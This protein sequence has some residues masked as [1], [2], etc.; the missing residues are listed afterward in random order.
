MIRVSV[1]AIVILSIAAALLSACSG[2]GAS[3]PMG[4][5][6]VPPGE[7]TSVQVRH[8]FSQMRAVDAATLYDFAGLDENEVQVYGTVTHAAAAS[9]LLVNVPVSVKQLRISYRDSQGNLHARAKVPVSLVAGQTLEVTALAGNPTLEVRLVNDSDIPDTEVYVI[10]TG[11]QVVLSGNSGMATRQIGSGQTVPAVNLKTVDP[12]PSMTWH[13]PYKNRDLPVYTFEVAH[14][15]GGRLWVS[16]GTPIVYTSDADPTAEVP[17]RLDKMEFAYRPGSGTGGGADLTS[18][19]YYGIP[20]ELRALQNGSVQDMRT[21]YASSKTIL[22]QLNSLSP[23]MPSTFLSPS[24]TPS[25]SPSPSPVPVAAP[26]W[27]PQTQPMTTFLRA[28]GPQTVAGAP[29]A[30]SAAPYTSFSGYMTQIQKSGKPI[31]LSGSGGVG[32]GTPNTTYDYAAAISPDGAGGYTVFMYPTQPMDNAPSGLAPQSTNPTPLPANLPIYLAL[33]ANQLD[34]NI[35]SAAAT[36]WA[37]PA[38]M[39]LQPATKNS[40]YATIVGDFVSA[41]QFGYVNSRVAPNDSSV[42]YANFPVLLPF[43]LCRPTPDDGQYN[44]YA[45]IFY[46]LS[47]AYGFPFSDRSGRI[48]PLLDIS[49]SDAMQ[50]VVMNDNRFDA[51]TGVTI[52]D[53]QSTQ[54]S[55]SWN[56]AVDGDGGPAGAYKVICSD[57]FNPP[58]TTMSTTTSAVVTGLNPGTVYQVRVESWIS[59]SLEIR[60]APSIPVQ[61]LTQGTAPTAGS[62]PSFFGALLTTPSPSP[63]GQTFT[64]GSSPLPGSSPLHLAGGVGLNQSLLTVTGYDPNTNSQNATL[65]QANVFTQLQSAPSGFTLVNSAVSDGSVATA[66]P[67]APTTQVYTPGVGGA[68]NLTMGLSFQPNPPKV[69]GSV[70]IPPASPVPS[71]FPTPIPFPS[72]SV[73]P[74]PPG[75]LIGAPT[76][77]GFSPPFGGAGTNLTVSGTYFLQGCTLLVGGVA[78]EGFEPSA[79]GT[80]IQVSLPPNVESGLITVVTPLGRGSSSQS[81]I[82]D[83]KPA[84]HAPSPALGPPGTQVT[85]PG[86]GFLTATQVA[87]NGVPLTLAPSPAP[88]P[89]TE[90]TFSIQ[91]DRTILASVPPNANAT[92]PV[93]V[94]NPTGTGTSRAIFTVNPPTFNFAPTSGLVGTPITLT[95]TSG[96]FLGATS[97]LFAGAPQ[98]TITSND[99]QQ[100]VVNVPA[101]A[102]AGKLTVVYPKINAVSTQ[103]FTPTLPTFGFAPSQ[104]PIGTQVTLTATGANTFDGAT[105]VLIGNGPVNVAPPPG[106]QTL[107]VNVPATATTGP[108]TVSFPAGQDVSTQDFTL[109]PPAFIASPSTSPYFETITLTATVG[110]LLGVTQINLGAS[111]ITKFSRSTNGSTITF[112]LPFGAG[113][114]NLNV[115]T[116]GVTVNSSNN[117]FRVVGPTVTSFSPTSGAPGTPITIQGTG[118]LAATLTGSPG[119]VSNP[120]FFGEILFGGQVSKLSYTVVSDEEITT[121]VPP[122]AQTGPIEVKNLSGG[123]AST[124]IF[125]VE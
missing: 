50:V 55:V 125:K 102:V 74:T 17:F 46:N 69:P 112:Q 83:G 43:S 65:D 95:A 51:P 34:F 116:G 35:Y 9:H 53:V 20:L 114:G 93:S 45:A 12:S 72:P 91:D 47:D 19:D 82:F 104:G 79:D 3:G 32:Y 2:G 101:G 71:P 103:N 29:G 107:Q 30:T 97:V 54:L 106:A 33:P 120:G 77:T 58:I 38:P 85:I 31:A 22:K 73:T 105:Q 122:N 123:T 60:S 124:L 7:S 88:S 61:A 16:Y 94:T 70:L 11:T 109:T 118:F 108:V 56:A 40:I 6:N 26:G 5:A 117:P 42:W 111:N 86:L 100:L 1:L 21:F 36:S 75:N 113:T 84:V 90:G 39:S 37:V 28:L 89:L 4:Q 96:N 76:V 68:G 8:D 80:T 110:N 23:D 25:G 18:L 67:Q 52:S 92:G 81:F 62:S 27:N 87:F 63:S 121:T 66:T 41:L 59:E 99:G 98:P 49:Q 10:L 115:S 14:V 24:S 64:L 15:D 57:G 78:V 48:S 13:S 44:P 119:P